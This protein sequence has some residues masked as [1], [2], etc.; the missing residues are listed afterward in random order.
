MAAKSVKGAKGT[1]NTQPSGSGSTANLINRLVI[2]SIGEIPKIEGA[3]KQITAKLRGA[4]AE[5][6]EELTPGTAFNQ[7]T[8]KLVRYDP[9]NALKNADNWQIQ[10]GGTEPHN[11]QS[12]SSV[13]TVIIDANV[14]AAYVASDAD[15]QTAF[16][17]VL[18]K[19]HRDSFNSGQQR[20]ISLK[21]A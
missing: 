9:Q 11:I 6:I 8:E 15:T 10:L 14:T 2:Q 4:V 5:L 12:P 20:H 16:I 7:H 3:R 19:A 1:S 17:E 13:T 21:S 18:K